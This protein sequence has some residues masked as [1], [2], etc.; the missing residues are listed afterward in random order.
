[1]I[2]LILG[3]ELSFDAPLSFLLQLDLWGMVQHSGPAIIVVLAVLICFS[4][5]SWTVIFA[6]WQSFRGARQ[7]NARFLR[8]FRKS[9]GMLVQLGVPADRLKTISYGKERPQC[10]EASEVCY[11][12]N[13]R[14]HFAAGQ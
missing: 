11:Q 8:A 10:S 13:R 5:F 6:K 7:A 2:D 3:D 4:V 12:K 14:A 1:M 9:T